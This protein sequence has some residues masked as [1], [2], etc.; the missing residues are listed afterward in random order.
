MCFVHISS[1]K[2]CYAVRQLF[3]AFAFVCLCFSTSVQA[4]LLDFSPSYQRIIVGDVSLNSNNSDV[5]NEKKLFE[6][7]QKRLDKQPLPEGD[8]MSFV[9]NQ[10]NKDAEWLKQT[11]KSEGYYQATV[12]PV[13]DKAKYKAQFTIYLGQRYHFDKVFFD[14]KNYNSDAI[15]E[16]GAGGPSLSDGVNLP[17]IKRMEARLGKPARAENVVK[18][19]V[20]IGRWLEED[21]CS[22][23][24]SL[25]H[26][27]TLNHNSHTVSIRYRI[28]IGQ[29]AT[30]GEVNFSGNSTLSKK[31]FVQQLNLEEG[32]C[33]RK[34]SLQKARAKLQRSDLLEKVDLSMPK[35][36][37]ADGSVPVTFV[38]K[39][40]VQRTIKAGG[41]YSTDLGPGIN[42]G[43]EHRNFLGEGEKFVAS[44]SLAAIE[45]R[46]EVKLDS[47]FFQ[48]RDQQLHTSV[49]LEREDSD[50]F[51]TAELY[52]G[53]NITRDLSDDQ[54][55][56]LGGQYGL[57]RIDD[58]YGSQNVALLSLPLFFLYDQRDDLLDPLSGWMARLDIAPTLDT[59]DIGTAFLKSRVEGSYYL[60]LSPSKR[61]VLAFR[62][63]VGSLIG[64]ALAADV[65]A[66]ERFYAGGGGSVRGVGYQLAGP[67]DSLGNPVGGRSFLELSS[68]LRIRVGESYGV[69]AFLDGGN[70]WEDSFPDLSGNLRW[71]AGVGARYYTGFGPIRADLA[72]PLNRREEVDDAWQV[73]FSIGQAF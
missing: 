24:Y 68:E 47:P 58:I 41:S 61:Q 66:T 10:F 33:F 15:N 54:V 39:E 13:F 42:A 8:D 22:F 43:W 60:S 35:Q 36:P 17:D 55:I 20:E 16:V 27:A 38:V 52:F 70:S 3:M 25:V 53:G 18:D 63:A 57:S 2:V 9:W 26:E 71:G 34:E 64:G 51:R 49:M 23:S 50:A 56:G 62:S 67:L 31:W 44:V 5:D 4:A 7:L 11:L 30:L 69:V 72:V 21:Q 29:P 14:V 73:Y 46:A 37:N 28:V 6:S 59:L 12:N 48:R 45:Q 65:P 40:Q 1:L 32:G 19:M